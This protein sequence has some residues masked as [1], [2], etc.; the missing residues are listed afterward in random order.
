M[1]NNSFTDTFVRLQQKLHCV[2]LRLLKD[3]Y[4]AEDAMQDT[5]CNLWNPD[6]PMTSDEARFKLFA[7]LRNVC[8]NKLKKRQQ[9][10][11]IDN[12]EIFQREQPLDESEHI[13]TLLFQSLTPL[14]LKIIEMMLS[15]EMEYA[16][17]ARHLDIS[18]ETVR[19]NVCRARKKMRELYKRL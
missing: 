15:Q 6:L 17:I 14:Q 5:F 2:A 19:M 10:S 3:E 18:V 16:E 12:S 4:E 8:L 11:P 9:V 1:S 13:K 7:V